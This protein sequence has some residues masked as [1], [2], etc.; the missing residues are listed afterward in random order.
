MWNKYFWH[1]HIKK[2]IPFAM[3]DHCMGLFAK[4]VASKS[5][6]ERA[7]LKEG[8]QDHRDRC[9]GFRKMHELRMVLG[10]LYKELFL[11]MIVD[12]MDNRKTQMPRLEGKLHSKHLDNTGKSH[13]CLVDCLVV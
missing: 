4:L 5:D 7:I 9:C 2:W 6:A 8:R 10:E 3:C 12:G 11:S 13:L 1:V